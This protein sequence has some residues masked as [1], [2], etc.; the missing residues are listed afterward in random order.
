MYSRYISSL[1]RFSPL[2]LI[3]LDF[4][5]IFLSSPFLVFISRVSLLHSLY[6]IHA[7]VL[8]SCSFIYLRMV[9][10]FPLTVLLFL[11][12]SPF[13]LP[14]LFFFF[15]FFFLRTP[16]FLRSILLSLIRT[17]DTF[18]LLSKASVPHSPLASLFCLPSLSSSVISRA[19]IHREHRYRADDF[20]QSW[21]K[22]FV[23]WLSFCDLHHSCFGFDVL[24]ISR[25]CIILLLAF[26]PFFSETGSPLHSF[27]FTKLSRKTL[28]PLVL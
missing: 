15:P 4:L 8:F 12:Y 18:F 17:P 22:S 5:V 7:A 10:V 21:M 24:R 28:L 19:I 13:F 11:F 25:P 1:T 6:S 26:L 3:P 20:Y 14:V 23:I 9:P 2:S 16:D 27:T